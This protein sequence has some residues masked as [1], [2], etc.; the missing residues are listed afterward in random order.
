MRRKADFIAL[1]ILCL[2]TNIFADCPH[3]YILI[4]V[5]I[6]LNN[7]SSLKGYIPYYGSYSN[8]I[9]LLT[10]NDIKSNILEAEH[11]VT[12]ITFCEDFYTFE[13]D[14][15]CVNPEEVKEIGLDGINKI[16]FRLETKYGG[17]GQVP[18]LSPKNI[19]LMTKGIYEVK[20]Y[21]ESCCDHIFVNCNPIISSEEFDFFVRL[22]RI[23]GEPLSQCMNHPDYLFK[24]IERSEGNNDSIQKNIGSIQ[25]KIEVLS[26]I[27]DTITKINEKSI[28]VPAIQDFNNEYTSLQN[29]SNAI[30]DFLSSDA[31]DSYSRFL[32]NVINIYES[33][34]GI[35]DLISKTVTQGDKWSRINAILGILGKHY[36]VAYQKNHQKMLEECDVVF[37]VLWWD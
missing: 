25:R 7:S 32:Q 23:Y 5:E 6:I 11:K 8:K 16:I 35:M 19:E 33:D 15:F 20:R 9:P 1:L 3:C 30:L 34:Q 31:E 21:I 36:E 14:I 13:D 18:F 28:I 27:I 24:R 17:A 10:G 37:L 26:N 4:D 2:F 22:L 12:S 29:L